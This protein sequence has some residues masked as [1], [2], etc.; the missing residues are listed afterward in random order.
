MSA[1]EADVFGR[2]W[3]RLLGL[4]KKL[5]YFFVRCAEEVLQGPGTFRIELPHMERTPRTR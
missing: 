5:P 4:E 2:L 1:V 3:P